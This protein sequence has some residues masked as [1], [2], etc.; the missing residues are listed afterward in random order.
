MQIVR[1]EDA[2]SLL[3]LAGTF[4]R[5]HEGENQLVL[6]IA[7]NA[8][9]GRHGY[10]PFRA[11][12]VLDDG[13]PVAA[14]VQTP[15]RNP[16]IA[17]PLADDALTAL[18]ET[19]LEDARDVPGVTGNVPT[20]DRFV[21]A[22]TSRTGERATLSFDQGLW[23]LGRVEDVERPPGRAE[24]ARPDEADLVTRWFIDFEAE[25]LSNH[26]PPEWDEVHAAIEERLADDVSGAW[27]W[28]VEGEPVSIAGFAGPTGTG[29]RIGPV[30]T[31]PEHRRCGYA[32]ALVADL[33]A[34][35]LERGYERCFLF[36]D[37]SNPTANRIYARIGYRQIAESKMLAFS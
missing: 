33:S 26:E 27:A 7:A 29:I 23:E 14:A 24:P 17:D 10:S 15:P 31:L 22:W 3:E 20:V 34:Q 36:T 12:V 32:T 35:L 2:P 4:L 11:W 6:G 9:A 5:R 13:E 28:R 30:Y 1:V 18:L 25:A 21:E 37:L 16:V 8:A 19:L